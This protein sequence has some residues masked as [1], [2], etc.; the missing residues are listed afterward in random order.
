M[1]QTVQTYSSGAQAAN[2]NV[3]RAEYAGNGY[4]NLYSQVGDGNTYLLDVTGKK[5]AD[6]TNIEIYKSSGN[7]A[8]LFK[9][10]KNDDGTYRIYTGASSDASCIE[11]AGGSSAAG[12]NVQQY[13]ANGG[14]NQ[15]WKLTKVNYKAA[16]T[17]ASANTA[18]VSDAASASSS[19][20]ASSSSSE[21]STASQTVSAASDIAS[22]LTISSD[23]GSGATFSLVLTNNS[24]TSYTGSWTVQ[25]TSDREISQVWNGG[26]LT[27]L[28][29]GVYQI[30]S[31]S[32]NGAWA[33][34]ESIT[35]T[36]SMGNGNGASIGDVSI[37]SGS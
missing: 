36:G 13:T 26:T 12:A 2:Y 16:T 31:P 4:Y 8:Q 1:L 18:S 29:N 28:G 7:S 15:S 14:S 9:F 30:T 25:L 27:S 20:A 3:W 19:A 35:I 22:S 32:W 6:G 37:V 10:V 17:S 21:A 11:V 24:S 5:A 23:W 34:G 33:A